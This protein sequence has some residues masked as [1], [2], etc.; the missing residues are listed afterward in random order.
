MC[1]ASSLAVRNI[2]RVRKYLSK[3]QVERL[4][5]R[6]HLIK[7]SIIIIVI[8]LEKWHF[9]ISLITFKYKA[10]HNMAHNIT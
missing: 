10:M 6:F 9:N 8:I 2:G 5:Q 7:P 1:R 3:S 4:I